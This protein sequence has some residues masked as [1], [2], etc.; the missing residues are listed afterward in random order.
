MSS[1]IYN[2]TRQNVNTPNFLTNGDGGQN[3]TNWTEGSYTAATRPSGTFT[4]SSGA[5]AF[6]ITSTTTAPLGAGLTSLLFTK[7]AGANRQGRCAQYECD[8]AVDYR[9]KVLSI[10]IDYIINSGTFVAGSNTTDS[11]LIWYAAFYDGSTWTTAEPSSI[12]CFSNLTTISAWFNAQIQTPYN[13][14][15]M[16]LIAYVAET[17]TTAWE[18]KAVLTVG[19]SQYVYGTPITDWQSY[20]PTISGVGTATNVS[21]AYSKM[22]QNLYIKGSF[23]TGTPTASQ[24][25]ITL[26][27][28]LTTSSSIT[29]NSVSGYGSSSIAGTNSPRNFYPLLQPSVAY[30]NIG[31]DYY[32]SATQSGL[33]PLNGNTT[34]SPTNASGITL[35]FVS[36]PIQ[37]TGWSS[38]VQMSDQTTQQVVAASFSGTTASSIAL[39]QV[40]LTK[41]VDTTGTTS[42]NTWVVPVQGNYSISA[43]ATI[44]TGSATLNDRALHIYI[45]GSTNVSNSETN[46]YFSNMT[47]ET[48]VSLNA[49]QVISFYAQS[50]TVTGSVTI[51]RATIQRLAGPSSIA[52]TDTVAASYWLSANFAASTTVPI[53]FDS[54]EFDYQGSVTTSATAWK[55]TAPVAGLYQISGFMYSSLVT[56][57]YVRIYKNGVFYKT[58]GI[59]LAGTAAADSCSQF[60]LLAGEYI[61]IRPGT[62]ATFYGGTLTNDGT[63]Q[64]SIC[65]VGNY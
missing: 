45:D 1:T 11:S 8:L 49:G 65:K 4:A 40:T 27:S 56:A 30:I 19:P 36:G 51:F 6:T 64:I 57:F 31:T 28:G 63:S 2:Q 48:I 5:S 9:A 14:T 60:R 58:F 43:S 23:T 47:T 59:N 42:G 7:T 39:T 20:T 50:A 10:N 25:Q 41:I 61:D 62:A 18:V 15:K 22:G 29:A 37:I 32:G 26:P 53:N 13:A 21:F 17:A 44:S 33:S 54:K 16:R 38:C 52:A 3:T 34:G 24:V 55:F 12:K 35:N 46:S